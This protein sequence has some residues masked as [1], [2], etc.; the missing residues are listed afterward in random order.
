MEQLP[1]GHPKLLS[2]WAFYDWANSVYSLVIASAI[3][4][5]FYGALTI[6]RDSE[7]NKISDSVVFLGTSFNND[8]LISYVTSI[9]FLVV[10][11]IS[12]FLSGISDYIGN[13]KAFL[14]F[15]CFLG[16]ISCIGL[17]WFSLENLLFGIICYMLALIGFWGSLVFYNSYLP[18]IVE[19]EGQDNLSARGYISGY[20]G[21]VIL[22]IMCL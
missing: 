7:G 21:S 1:K 15:F 22:L 17:Y 6:V 2:A 19:K 14:R 4:P 12:P 5:I 10:A 11:I 20:F 3:F 8:A 16:A 13:K 9:S 18:D